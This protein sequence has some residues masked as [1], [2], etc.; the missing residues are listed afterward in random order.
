[1]TYG[2][3]ERAKLVADVS[4]ALD[5]KVDDLEETLRV[6]AERVTDAVGD[7]CT[8]YLLSASNVRLRPRL[9]AQLRPGSRIV[10]HNFGMGDWEPEKVE[11]FVDAVGTTRTLMLWRIR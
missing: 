6:V 3:V 2:E 11:T 8:L 10:A 1:M 7:S 4:R 5:A 9:Q